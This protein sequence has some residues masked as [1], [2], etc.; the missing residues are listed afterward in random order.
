MNADRA[1]STFEASV[2]PSTNAN[3]ERNVNVGR[4]DV[5]QAGVLAIFAEG[6]YQIT[7]SEF[8]LKPTRFDKR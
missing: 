7:D 1:I 4:L 2:P 5:A 6:S 8:K 3:Q